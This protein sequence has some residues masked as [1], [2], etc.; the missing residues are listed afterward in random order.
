MTALTLCHDGVTIF[1]G[2]SQG[3]GGLLNTTSGVIKSLDHDG[4]GQYEPDLNCVWQI[5]VPPDHNVRLHFDQFDLAPQGGEGCLDLSDY[6]Q[7]SGQF[8]EL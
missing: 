7:V 8:T 5:V 6:L 4:N 3:C 1:V 2:P